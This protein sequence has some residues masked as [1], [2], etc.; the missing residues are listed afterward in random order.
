MINKSVLF[1]FFSIFS[2]T[3]LAC[4]VQLP[5]HIVILGSSPNLNKDIKH[6]GCDD[7]SLKRVTETML[8]VEGKITSFQ[9]VQMLK[10][11]NLDIK[12]R[13]RLIEVQHLKH[14]VREQLLLPEGVKV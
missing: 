12:I 3:A 2:F 14:L 9:L 1:L 13:P 4:E 5:Q 11:K 7:E 6:I 10:E 8:S